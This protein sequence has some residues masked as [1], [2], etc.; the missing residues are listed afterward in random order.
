MSTLSSPLI[1]RTIAS[2]AAFVLCL[3]VT[4]SG[5]KLRAPIHSWAPPALASAVGKR[6]AVAP[7]DGE[8]EVATKIEKQLMALAPRDMGRSIEFVSPENIPRIPAIQLAGGV[9]QSDAGP[10]CGVAQA[11]YTMSFT[12]SDPSEGAHPLQSDIALASVARDQGYDFILSGEVLADRSRN[13]TKAEDKSLGVS[14]RLIAIDSEGADRGRG[15]PV[16]VNNEMAIDTYPDLA[17]M[18][19]PNDR[20]VNA[21]VRETL[22]LVAP[23]IRRE[24]VFLAVPRFFP[25]ARE[26][27][28]GNTAARQGQWQ[29]AKRLWSK[30]VQ[31]HP[32]QAAATH[33]LAL[34]FAASQEFSEAK[35]LARKAIRMHPTASYKRTLVWIETRQRDYHEAFGLAEPPEGWFVTRAS[36]DH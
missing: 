24:N 1:G 18:A 16:V 5:C 17:I 31:E 27:R 35:R 26:V 20:L 3:V 29:E 33:N 9:K 36:G 32:L 22:K 28:R 15:M 13:A 11:G 34:A 10:A 7:V 25:G 8:K 19:N 4:L 2:E 6:V 30:A 14:W 23:S 21:A 12:D